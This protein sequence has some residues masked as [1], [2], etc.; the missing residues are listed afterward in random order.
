MMKIIDFLM[1]N[2]FILVIVFG[3]LASLFGKAGS[4]KKP[5]QM[6]SFGGGSNPRVGTPQSSHTE[7]HSLPERSDGQQVYQTAP[8]EEQQRS[9]LQRSQPV[10]GYDAPEPQAAALDR[11]ISRTPV[12]RPKAENP[13]E[14]TS[15]KR[16]ALANAL[17]GDD[18]R[19]AVLWA[20]ILGPPRAKKPYRK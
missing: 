16:S 13:L 1:N 11:S 15:T 17:Q 14:V 20:E 5:G 6:P 12:G 4:K 8:K 19:K 18:I 2:I 10:R 3:A 7:D 9:N